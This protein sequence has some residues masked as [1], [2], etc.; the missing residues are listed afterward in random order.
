MPHQYITIILLITMWF[1]SNWSVWNTG[2]ETGTTSPLRRLH[3]NTFNK[4][5]SHPSTRYRLH[6]Y[7]SN[8]H[9]IN[10]GAKTDWNTWKVSDQ[11]RVGLNEL[12]KSQHL[13]PFSLSAFC[14]YELHTTMAKQ[15]RWPLQERISFLFFNWL[16]G[17]LFHEQKAAPSILRIIISI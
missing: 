12:M 1:S 13:P 7:F 6:T 8:V 16:S 9:G 4:T 15:C 5:R 14:F 2:K 11:Q 3:C 10:I 17:V